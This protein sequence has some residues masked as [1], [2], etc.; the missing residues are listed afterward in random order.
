ML[1]G[2][3]AGHDENAEDC[4][5]CDGRVD[6]YRLDSGT[7]FICPDCNGTGKVWGFYGMTSER[8]DKEHFGGLKDYRTSEGWEMNYLQGSN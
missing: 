2:M 7:H 4:P 6:R 3:L 5:A 1:G 8:G